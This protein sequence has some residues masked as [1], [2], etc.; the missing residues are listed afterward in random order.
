MKVAIWIRFCF[1]LTLGIIVVLGISEI[2]GGVLTFFGILISIA[3]A[4]AFVR[5]D[6]MLLRMLEDIRDM[7]YSVG[8]NRAKGK[9]I[10]VECGLESEDCGAFCISCGEKL[11]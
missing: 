6:Y 10:C 4:L 11:A 9:K 2:I 1:V 3:I 8:I 7:K 5:F